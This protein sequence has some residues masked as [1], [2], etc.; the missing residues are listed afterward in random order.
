MLQRSNSGKP[1]QTF[2]NLRFRK[3]MKVLVTMLKIEE[4]AALR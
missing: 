4:N 2:N 1:N 3:L